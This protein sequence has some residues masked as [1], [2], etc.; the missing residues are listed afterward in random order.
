MIFTRWRKPRPPEVISLGL[1]DGHYP[2]LSHFHEPRLALPAKCGRCSVPNVLTTYTRG[3]SLCRWL[4]RRGRLPLGR[5]NQLH[6]GQ[7]LVEP[8]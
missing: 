6:G 5:R 8:G 2:D 7:K 4:A 3:G 1:P